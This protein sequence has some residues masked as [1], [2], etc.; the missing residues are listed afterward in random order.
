M[1]NAA[2]AGE[3]RRLQD[4][5]RLANAAIEDCERQLEDEKY[6]RAQFEH[7]A[8]VVNAHRIELQELADFRMRACADLGEQLEAYKCRFTELE[9]LIAELYNATIKPVE[10]RD[11]G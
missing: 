1:S 10:V 3:N 2:L 4:S 8:E 5:L 7:A 6:K 9:Q 11:A